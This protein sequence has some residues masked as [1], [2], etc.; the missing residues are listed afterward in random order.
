MTVPERLFAR[1]VDPDNGED[2]WIDAE[3]SIEELDLDDD[4]EEVG[5]YKLVRRLSVRKT[6]EVTEKK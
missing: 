5:E 3:E 2:P 1:M 4:A 6:F